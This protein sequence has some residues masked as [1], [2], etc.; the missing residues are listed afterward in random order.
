MR[1]LLVHVSIQL[2]LVATQPTL[3]PRN[4]QFWKVDERID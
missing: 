4:Q 1:D 2:D 3:Q